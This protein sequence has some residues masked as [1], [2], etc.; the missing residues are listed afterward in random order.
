MP[1]SRI[2]TRRRSHLHHDKHHQGYVTGLNTA[3]KKLDAALEAG[4]TASAETIACDMAFNGS[5]HILHSIL[6]TNMKPGGG[7]VP[8]GE[9][10][11]AI[12]RDFGSYEKFKAYFLAATNQ[13]K[14]SGWG[15]L[16]YRPLDGA[17]VVLEAQVH[18]NLTQWSVVPL[19]ALD[20]WEHAYYLQYQNQR[21]EWTK[22]FMEKLVNWDDVAARYAKAKK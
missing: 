20:V 15:I 16:A 6:W 10:A 5:G 9:L 17:L 22:T 14:G 13:V 4:D 12:D 2:W 1:W 7:G 11:E 19:L 8:T 21:P 18:E 3:Y